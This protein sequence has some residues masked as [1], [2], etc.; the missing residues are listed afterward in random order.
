MGRNSGQGQ[1]LIETLM[2]TLFL[3]GFYWFLLKQSQS[4]SIFN[5]SNQF[6]QEFVQ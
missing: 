3:A 1:V 6:K 5:S 2:L 4:L